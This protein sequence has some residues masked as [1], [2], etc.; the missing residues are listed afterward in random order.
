[1]SRE[2]KERQADFPDLSSGAYVFEV[3]KRTPAE[4]YVFFIH[5]LIEVLGHEL[6]F[7]QQ[8]IHL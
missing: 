4:K 1:M 8:Q 7:N 6:H 2:L 5:H 3:I